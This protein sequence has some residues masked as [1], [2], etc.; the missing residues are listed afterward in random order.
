MGLIDDFQPL[1]P[2]P[3]LEARLAALARRHHGYATRAELLAAGLNPG[4][5][6]HRARAGRLHRRHRGVYAIGYP[7]REPIA[8]AAAAVLGGGAGAVLSHGSAAALWGLSR[9]WPDP[10]EVTTSRDRRDPGIR[11]HRSAALHPRDVRTHHGIRTTSAARTALDIAPR[12]DDRALARMIRDA[13]IARWLYEAELIELADRLRTKSGAARVRTLIT[14]TG[15]PTRSDLEDT[16]LGLARRH[17]L[18]TPL[19]NTQVAG[20]QVDVLFAAERVIVEIDG[21]EYHRDH[22]NFEGDRARDAATLE[23]GYVTV[24]LTAAMLAPAAQAAT[25]RRLHAI[26]ASRGRSRSHGPELP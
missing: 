19:V 24:R 20:Y 6:A 12:L 2:T 14:G 11:W 10:P 16:F 23:A 26:L 18:P 17:G 8:L 21:W 7:R 3:S 15:G 22:A 1:D 25:A 13:R 9:N 4:A 5:I